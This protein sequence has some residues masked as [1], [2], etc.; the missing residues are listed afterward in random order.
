MKLKR[1]PEDFEVE[2]LPSVVPAA[3]GRYTF[4]RLSKRGIGTIEAV[5]AICRRWN[6]PSGRVGY[7]GLKDRHAVTVQYVTIFD[8]PE[9][10]IHQPSL[11]L[12]PLG[13][14][15]RAYGPQDFTGNRFALV[16][17]DMTPGAAAE[18]GRQLAAASNDGVPNYFDDQRFG[19]VGYSGE[20]IGH[21]WLKGD[22]EKALKLALAE[23]NSFDRS[24]TKV[25]KAS[26]RE[27]WGNWPE[28]KAALDRSSER[29]IVTYLVDHPTDFTGAFAR[30]KRDLRGLYF[31]A[32]QSWLWN[33]MLAGWIERNTRP[34]QRAMVDLKVGALPFPVGLDPDQRRLIDERPLPLPSS[35]TPPP[36]GP[37]GEI[38]TEALTAFDLTWAD[39]RVKKL[40]DVF[41][42]KGSRQALLGV[43]DVR[44]ETFDDPLHRGKQAVRL[45]FALPKG[46]YA[47]MLVKRLTEA[48]GADD[49]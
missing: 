42:S 14:L 29:S 23:P 11:D 18:A 38:A 20:F 9:H 24:D 22:Y 39:V 31:S 13:R 8:G 34:E 40:K 48:S 28:A 27:H 26:L 16:L 12:E 10:A 30:L 36:D 35:R 4:Y 46:A 5:E 3:K 15:E 25:R 17:R 49:S 6:I 44:S 41:F 1:Q 45:E 37:L 19:S 7:G 21:A 33:L 43:G 32:F 47:T 2:E